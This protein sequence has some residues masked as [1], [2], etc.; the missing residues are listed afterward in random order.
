MASQDPVSP[1][2][3]GVSHVNGDS[4]NLSMKEMIAEKDRIE[5][6]LKELG[7]VLIAVC[8]YISSTSNI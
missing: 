8:H 1:A 2:R 3:N 5:A 7:S 4:S 6:E